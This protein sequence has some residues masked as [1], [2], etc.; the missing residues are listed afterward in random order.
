LIQLFYALAAAV[1]AVLC[2]WRLQELSGNSRIRFAQDR[3]VWG[4][5]ALTVF[6]LIATNSLTNPFAHNLHNDALAQ[7]VA[8]TAYWLLLD[9]AVT[10]RGLTLAVMALIP[11]LG[12]LVKQSLAIW[13]PL[14]GAYLLFF[15]R[16]RSVP[17]AVGFVA[18]ASTVLALLLAGCYRLWG[19]PF[20]YWTIQEMA[21]HVVSPLRSFEH[22]LNAWLYYGVGLVAGLVLLRGSQGR[23]LLGP[24][25]I[26]LIFL[27]MSSYT[28]GIEWMINHQG[29]GCLL[30][31]VWFLAALTKLWS[32]LLVPG[33]PQL[34]PIRWART[35]VGVSLVCLTFAGL[36][37]VW[38]PINSLPADARRYVEEIEREHAG[39]PVDKVLLDLGAWIAAKDLVVL[40][41]Q[42]P[43]IATRGSSRAKGDFSGILS[44]LEKRVYEKILVRNLD[45]PA[46]WY[47]DRT[48]WRQTSG[49]RQTL[50]E[51]YQES[52]RIK[53]VEGE[54]RFLLFSFEPVPFPVTRYG[55]KEI[56]ILTPKPDPR[57]E[58]ARA[59]LADRIDSH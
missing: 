12:F 20:W 53:A 45:A 9:Y 16:S 8:V 32:S 3:A 23:R 37:L 21:T 46:F 58:S 38:M 36:G 29:P 4:A 13:I 55:F 48:W 30:A 47:D 52:G 18:A 43:G 2:Y 15:D 54:K 31:G 50:L 42:A 41:D 49:I 14:Y 40:K 7:L 57:L 1:V 56:T 6:F 59:S 22:L 25:V 19:Q 39:L 51:N 34:S 17:R 11:A 33:I 10:R 44:R 24:W 5:I 26:W 27:L 28:S 35:G